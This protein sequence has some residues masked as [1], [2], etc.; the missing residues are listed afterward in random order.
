MDKAL[1]HLNRALRKGKRVG[2]D[3][4]QTLAQYGRGQGKHQFVL[5]SVAQPNG[6]AKVLQAQ[7]ATVGEAVALCANSYIDKVNSGDIS[8][9]AE[10]TIKIDIISYVRPVDREARVMNP[11]ERELLLQ[12]QQEGLAIGSEL[13]VAFLPEEVTAY[14]MLQSKKLQIE[15]VLAALPQRLLA[16]EKELAF[17]LSQAEKLPLY[18]FRTQAFALHKNEVKAIEN[19][20]LLYKEVDAADLEEAIRYTND[21]Y[22]KQVVDEKGKFVYSYLPHKQEV[23]A[24]YNILRHAGTTYSMLETYE[25]TGDEEV[26]DEADRAFNYL[27]A[28][29]K[30]YH[31]NDQVFRVVVEKDTM[32][33]GGNALAIIALAKYVDL[34][35]NKADLSLMQ[36][37]AKYIEYVQDAR[38][39]F[40]VHKQTY[41]TGNVINFESHYYPGEAILALVR[42]Y[43]LDNNERW[44][45]VAERAAAYII[46]RRDK[47][48]SVDTIAHDH[49]FLYALNELYRARPE[50]MYVRHALFI[51]EAMLNKQFTSKEKDGTW[52][53]GYSA[54]IT[55]P[56]GTP[57]ACRSEG[58]AAT[59]R[60]AKD[61]GLQE[62]A[63]RLYEAVRR[64]LTFQ[65]Q[66][67]VR[68]ETAM[69]YAEDT[70]QWG[71]FQ[72]SFTQLDQRIDFTQH[73]ISSLLAGREIM[74]EAST[75]K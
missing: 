48:E 39:R 59:Y 28:Q 19:G 43:Q 18:T 66:L 54:S 40:V 35:G 5:L 47:D 33:L 16:N 74:I 6:R 37:L 50:E 55:P 14:T 31:E 57:V 67:Q 1:Y 13:N 15:H 53:G 70:K 12:K 27:R 68:P 4:F 45:N 52:Y 25:F 30:T 21:Y 26:W 51:A 56:Q 24:K 58:L 69:Y 46:Q 10:Q 38:G 73:N 17:Q 60:L 41:S 20:H 29:M 42:L 62:E 36:D 23:E 75:E 9:R 34:S 71:A 64:G 44:L 8:Q 72:R 22:F 11:Q 63:N 61:L 65:L 7:A 2:A 49:W 3:P 32:K